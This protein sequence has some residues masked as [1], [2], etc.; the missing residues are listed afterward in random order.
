MNLSISLALLLVA[1]AFG[2]AFL[3]G[4]A[5]LGGGSILIAVLYACDLAPVE[6]VPLFAAVQLVSNTTRTAAYIRHV[7]W[8]AAGYFAATAVPATFL[9]APYAAQIDAGVIK[10]ILAGFMLASLA[11]KVQQV[12]LHKVPSFM[13]AGVLNG[14]LGLFIGATGLFVGRLFFRPEWKKQTT[15]ATLALTQVIGHG[16]RV[17]AYGWAGYSVFSNMHLL[18][19]MALAVI[20]GTW[21]GKYANGK[22]SEALFNKIF[23]FLLVVLS[24]KLFFDGMHELL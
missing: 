24:A 18:V 15:I 13:L 7:H 3:S 22:I 16:L 8:P 6:A 11:P 2:T 17:I 5:G 23:I 12:A 9:I 20:F 10:V 14:S 19:P 1:S 4:I 21:L